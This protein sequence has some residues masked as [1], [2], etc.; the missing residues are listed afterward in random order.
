MCKH[1]TNVLLWKNYILLW[2]P[3][4]TS[5]LDFPLPCLFTIE[6]FSMIQIPFMEN[7]KYALRSQRFKASSVQFFCCYLTSWKNTFKWHQ[8]LLWNCKMALIKKVSFSC[9]LFFKKK[10]IQNKINIPWLVI[11]A[12]SNLEKWKH[13]SVNQRCTLWHALH[14]NVEYKS[15]W[16]NSYQKPDGV[17]KIYF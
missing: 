17:L 16:R 13:T 1:I 11:C 10:K 9:F 4:I 6:I 7:A 15:F 12:S 8:W 5:F 14:Y 3:P 2:S